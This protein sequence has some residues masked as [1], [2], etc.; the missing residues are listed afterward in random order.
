MREPDAHDAHDAHGTAPAGAAVHP[1]HLAHHFKTL[2]QQSESVAFGVWLFLAT[3]IMF[4]GG[5]IMAYILYR[6]WY[7]HDF[8]AGSHLLD[9]RMG[10]T[11]TVVLITSSVT[12]AMAVWA[13]QVGRARTQVVYLVLTILLGSTFLGIKAIEYTHKWHEHVVPGPHFAWHGPDAPHVRMFFN[14][15]FTMTGL[16]ALHMIVG[17][18]LVAALIPK[19][20]KGRFG[21]DYNHPV[22]GTGLYWHF[23]DIVWIFLF[24]LLYLIGRH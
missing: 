5:L 24:P 9:I 17:I 18:G 1:P 7:P 11:N 3:E 20:W 21:P 19:C 22:E 10:A 4:F 12:M 8:A 6:I 14:L 2:E 15:Y 13:A 23:V 16:H